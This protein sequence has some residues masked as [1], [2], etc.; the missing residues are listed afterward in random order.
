VVN[1]LT[2]AQIVQ[3]HSLYQGEWWSVGRSLADVRTMLQYSDFIFGVVT[4]DSQQ[5]LAFAR[6]LT[7]CVFKALVL[8]LIVHPE[9]RSVGL[10]SFLME[11]I[12]AHPVLSHVRHIELYC[13]PERMQFYHRYGFTSELGELHLMRRSLT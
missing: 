6:V 3:L 5:L 8:D 10:G 2:E 12:L 1:T 4:A 11:H 7:D 9:H 13:L